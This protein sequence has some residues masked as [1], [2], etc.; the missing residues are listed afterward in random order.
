MEIC[1]LHVE[2]ANAL[3]TIRLR[4]LREHPASFSADLEEEERHTVEQVAEQLRNGPPHNFTLGAFEAGQLVGIGSLYRY[5]RQKT[6]H[7]A[8]I[9]GM[10]VAPEARGM[11]VGKAILDALI[12]HART[13]TGLTDL[14]LAVTVGNAPAR[15]L[16]TN[17]GFQPYGI[18][19][20]YI[21]AGSRYHDIE[22]MIL[23][24]GIG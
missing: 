15:A 12:V 23:H 2:D 10:Y 8:M 18:E 4:S 6:R 9:G 21:Q 19:P 24:L 3:R 1:L 5:P 20:R 14:T 7:K 13:L 17:A 16:Y 22:W 11:R